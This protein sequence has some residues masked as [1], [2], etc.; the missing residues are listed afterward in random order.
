MSENKSTVE[1]SDYVSDPA[2]PKSINL[3]LYRLILTSIL[4][5]LN[6]MATAFFMKMK[7]KTYSTHL[8]ISITICYFLIGLTHLMPETMKVYYKYE[9]PFGR[10]TC[11][12]SLVLFGFNFTVA[13]DTMLILA[14]HRYQLLDTNCKGSERMTRRRFLILL[15]PWL[16]RLIY[17]IL[18]VLINHLN[19][20]IDVKRCLINHNGS[21]LFFSIIFVEYPIATSIVVI[22][23]INIMRL[24][25]KR[26]RF[27]KLMGEFGYSFAKKKEH[28]QST[29]ICTIDL[30]KSNVELPKKSS[31]IKLKVIAAENK[32]KCTNNCTIA[33]PLLFSSL[34]IDKNETKIRKKINQRFEKDIKAIVCILTLILSIILTN[35]SFIFIYPLLF[36]CKCKFFLVDYIFFFSISGLILNPII[37]F[38][39]HAA[40]R[41]SMFKTANQLYFQITRKGKKLA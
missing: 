29:N 3:V 36:I 32:Q 21:F 28:R 39:F 20:K 23:I 4:M 30:D 1:Y 13:N 24:I 6:L 5:A 37:L 15:L 2:K 11:Y 16:Y 12:L 18:N 7:K 17:M 38:V 10:F 35:Y 33:D 22:N 40:L 8:F 14:I 34:I 19:N 9:W 41:K 26:N 27:I 25:K 31:A